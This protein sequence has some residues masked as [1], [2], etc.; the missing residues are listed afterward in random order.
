MT[1]SVPLLYVFQVIL[2]GA[3]VTSQALL[4]GGNVRI[5]SYLYANPE[6]PERFKGSLV[7]SFNRGEEGRMVIAYGHRYRKIR[8]SR[9][10]TSEK[11]RQIF[12]P[13]LGKN[14]DHGEKVIFWHLPADKYDL[15]VVQPKSMTLHEGV[16]L[17]KGSHPDKAPA[18]YFEEIKESLG[19]R[20][21]RIG[22]W[23]GFFDGKQ[24][25]RFE[26]DGIKAC[27][28]LQQMRLGK[29]FA[30]SGDVL[31]GSV[32]SIDICWVERGK[33]EGSGWQVVTRQQFYRDELPNKVYF[34]HQFTPE[35][36]GIRVGTR[37]KVVGPITLP[38]TP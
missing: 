4:A 9:Q 26:S 24:F 10:G 13:Y 36:Q 16:A 5:G 21:D 37:K 11:D 29:A 15:V 14:V 32:H 2:G 33:R 31:K 12:K 35:L 18:S 8:K 23:E 27:V 20:K 6:N 1:K 28:L 30:E 34:K 17:L 19:P 3:M 38:D 25:E 22:G 7:V